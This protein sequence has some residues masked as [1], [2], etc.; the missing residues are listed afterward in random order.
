[1]AESLLTT[2]KTI[3]MYSLLEPPPPL[4]FQDRVAQQFH[5]A[6][7]EANN[8]I[9]PPPHEI[10]LLTQT[11]VLGHAAIVK[12][13]DGAT[14]T[15]PVGTHCLAWQSPVSDE[16]IWDYVICIVCPREGESI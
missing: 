1:M 14:M 5:E 15:C 3:D 4:S 7:V 9:A 8:G 16:P 11:Y 12:F 13:T 2:R 10:P 6:I